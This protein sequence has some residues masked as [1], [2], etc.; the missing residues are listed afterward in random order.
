MLY[1][2]HAYTRMFQAHVSSVSSVSYVQ[3]FHLD[4][5][6]VDRG[7]AGRGWWLSLL[8]LL[9]GRSHP[10]WFPVRGAGP[11]TDADASAGA[12]CGR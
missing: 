1:R 8:L 10:T 9:L 3:M 6:K 12:G 2:L 5:S 4:I 11:A 7:V